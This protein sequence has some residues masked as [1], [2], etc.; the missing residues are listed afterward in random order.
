MSYGFTVVDGDY[1]KIGHYNST[2]DNLSWL[3]SERWL[4]ELKT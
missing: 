4:G 1:T 3:G 2:S